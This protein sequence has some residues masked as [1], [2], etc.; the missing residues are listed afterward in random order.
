M[1]WLIRGICL[2]SMDKPYNS[3]RQIV[4][5]QININPPHTPPTHT[6]VPS[7][8]ECFSP[9]NVLSLQSLTEAW[10]VEVQGQCGEWMRKC[11]PV[12]CA[13]SLHPPLL[14]CL[15]CGCCRATVQSAQPS[16]QPVDQNSATLPHHTERLHC[17]HLCV[18]PGLSNLTYF[19]LTHFGGQG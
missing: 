14:L 7:L 8:C 3:S 10:S 5:P 16:S 11:I 2:E 15:F 4:I 6:F 9:C 17:F 19:S 18:R 1:L 13:K 12:M